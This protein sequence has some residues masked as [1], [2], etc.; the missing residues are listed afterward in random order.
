L[1]EFF[2]IDVVLRDRQLDFAA[3]PELGVGLDR[4]YLG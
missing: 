1:F 3:V 4:R 2:E